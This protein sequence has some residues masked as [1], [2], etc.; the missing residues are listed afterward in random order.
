MKKIIKS[1]T[2]SGNPSKFLIHSCSTHDQPGFVLVQY[3]LVTDDLLLLEKES[4]SVVKKYKGAFLMRRIFSLR[5]STL[6]ALFELLGIQ[7]ENFVQTDG[8]SDE[9]FS[10]CRMDRAT[11]PYHPGLYE[12]VR[13]QR[14][15]IPDHLQQPTGRTVALYPE[16]PFLQ[17]GEASD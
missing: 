12:Y 2:L 5:L 4:F 17:K 16:I 10:V 14:I 1:F 9:G 15:F 8:F 7:I 6:M 3:I 11:N 13:R